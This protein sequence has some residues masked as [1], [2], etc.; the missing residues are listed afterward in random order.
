M[1]K[2]CICQERG[3]CC[4]CYKTLRY[5][6]HIPHREL[7]GHLFCIDCYPK[8]CDVYIAEQKIKKFQES[9]ND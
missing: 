1:K 7:D 9:Q 4:Y 8:A 6:I 3:C 2:E 5:Y